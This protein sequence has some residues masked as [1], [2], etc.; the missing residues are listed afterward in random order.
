MTD[1]FE[2]TTKKG[3]ALLSTPLLNKDTAFSEEER[4]K[5]ALNGLLPPHV[6]TLEE[7]VA[8]CYQSFSEASSPLAKHIYLRSLQDRNETLFYALLRAHLTEMMPII[9]TPVV[10]EACQKFSHIYRHNRGL[11]LCY[12]LKDK[13]SEMIEHAIADREIKVI[14]VT[15]GERILGLGDQG[16]DGM[17]IPIG[18]LSLYTACGGIEP[19]ATLPIVLDVGTN[20]VERRNH[21]D[22]LGWRH[23]RVTGEEYYQ[24]VDDFV[25]Q[26]KE[27][28]P[29]VLLQFEDFAQTHAYPLLEKYRETLCTFN[30]DIQGTAAVSV[31]S[32]LAAVKTANVKL[33]EQNIAVL[34]A[35]S[36]GCGI[37]EMLIQAMM[38]EGLSYTAASNKFYLVDRFGLL[39][40]DMEHLL[41]FQ[42]PLT[43]DSSTLASWQVENAKNISLLDVMK[44]A[45]PSILIGV[46]GVP[47]LFTKDIIKEMASHHQHPIVFPLSNP[48]SRCEAQPEDILHWTDGKAL[49]AT[50]SPFKPVDYHGTSIEIAQSNNSYIFPGMGLGIVA[51]Q[52]S[53]VSDEMF[54]EAS[55][56]LSEF[57]PLLK[58]HD[59]TMVPSLLPPL[60]EVKEVSLAIAF[61]VAKKAIEQGHASEMSDEELKKIIDDHFWQPKYHSY[62]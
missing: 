50:G 1:K 61:R 15:D 5:L 32:I 58:A 20:N 24:F 18:K 27:K 30:D 11:F 46:T 56:A 22:Y 37:S 55:I 48:T 38:R 60:S 54:M 10:G 25:Q 28:I 31:G 43:Q 39:Q 36:A 21:P 44:N 2:K 12:A 59:E 3:Q 4:Q 17:G 23:E 34:G 16:V 45:H 49:V 47:G 26:V 9:Y 42:K 14:V 53:Y 19:S 33:S 8:R 51:V 35:G 29:G 57:S 52:A 7:Q 62:L 41:D 6:E 40:S 13:M